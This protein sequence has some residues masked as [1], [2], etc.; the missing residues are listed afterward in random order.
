MGILGSIPQIGPTL[1]QAAKNKVWSYGS[2]LKGMWK[3]I[4]PASKSLAL[5]QS[6][7]TIGY[8]ILWQLEGT[9]DVLLGIIPIRAV[10]RY[11]VGRS[12]E[13][14]KYRAVAGQFFAH[15]RGGRVAFKV[16]M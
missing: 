11:E 7:K 5:K 12:S 14:M 8:E 16:V 6:I 4:D 10:Q 2:K 9:P 13:K 1:G 3:N 15:Q